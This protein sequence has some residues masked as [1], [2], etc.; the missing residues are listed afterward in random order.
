MDILDGGRKV[1]RIVITGGP[2]G[3]KTTSMKC[4]LEELG[5]EEFS[6]DYAVLVMAETATELIGGGI[7]PWNCLTP[8]SYQYLQMKLQYCKELVYAGAAEEIAKTQDKSIII[9]YDR[10]FMDNKAYS[11]DQEFIDILARLGLTEVECLSWYDAVFHLTTAAKGAE[12]FY[13]SDNNN[14]RTETL[15][16]AIVVD[17]HSL[18]AWEDH[19]N[20]VIFD[21]SGDFQ[22]KMD[23]LLKEL[24]HF[25][26]EEVPDLQARV[27]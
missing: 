6:K 14:T 1:I 8:D 24:R 25:L 15:E 18:H 21:N 11:S 20:R 7:A 13:G 19:P 10:G 2:C 5:K 17:D 9:L 16:E 3:G 4:L 22:D 12:A 26:R 27:G 23:R